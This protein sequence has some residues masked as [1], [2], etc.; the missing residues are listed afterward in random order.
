VE[1]D[2]KLLVDPSDQPAE[3]LI[4]QARVELQDWNM[5]QEAPDIPWE[6]VEAYVCGVWRYQIE[7][8]Q[9]IGYNMER[10][11]DIVAWYCEFASRIPNE[12]MHKLY[13]LVTNEVS[14]R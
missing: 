10:L 1:F 7:T 6:W 14:A 5:N 12:F 4:R 9:Q 13:D 11:R 2:L 8:K 3:N